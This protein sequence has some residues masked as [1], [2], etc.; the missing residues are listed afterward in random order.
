[1]F[2]ECIKAC[3]YA[4]TLKP[5]YDL[6]YNNICAAYN[7]LGQ[8]DRAITAAKKG[9]KLNAN[10]QFLKNNLAESISG[11]NGRAGKSD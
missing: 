6:A 5:D 8:W 7:K 11:K 10:N 9:L 4:L 3:D 1:M 2:N